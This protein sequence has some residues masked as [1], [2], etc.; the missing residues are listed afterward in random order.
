M[1][2]KK[3]E[4]IFMMALIMQCLYILAY[5]LFGV[6]FIQ[7]RKKMLIFLYSSLSDKKMITRMETKICSTKQVF[8]LFFKLSMNKNKID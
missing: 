8:N 7:K 6:F 3:I 4:I 5:P 1:E 2:E